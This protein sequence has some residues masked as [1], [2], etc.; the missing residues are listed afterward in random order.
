MIERTWFTCH[1]CK[2]ECDICMQADNENAPGE[3]QPTTLLACKVCADSFCKTCDSLYGEPTPTA[4]QGW[5]ATCPECGERAFF[6]IDVARNI[7]QLN[8]KIKEQTR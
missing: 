8:H 2:I 6:T 5:T 7:T 4:K 1:I 3:P